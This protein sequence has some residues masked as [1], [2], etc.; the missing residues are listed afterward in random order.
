MFTFKLIIQ[1]R[2]SSSLKKTNKREVIIS[3]KKKNT[4]AKIE[5]DLTRE[6]EQ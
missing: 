6:Y 1:P 4:E 3:E 5:E 2:N